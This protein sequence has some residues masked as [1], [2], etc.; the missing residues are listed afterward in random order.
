MNGDVYASSR[1]T[2]TIDLKNADIRQF[3]LADLVKVDLA[4]ATSGTTPVNF[5]TT[6]KVHVRVWTQFSYRVNP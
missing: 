4:L 3:N 1:S 2:F 6:D 5:R